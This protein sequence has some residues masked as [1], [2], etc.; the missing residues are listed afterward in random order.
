MTKSQYNGRNKRTNN[1]VMIEILLRVNT[2][3]ETKGQT[4]EQ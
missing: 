1:K 3:D 4:I 2:M